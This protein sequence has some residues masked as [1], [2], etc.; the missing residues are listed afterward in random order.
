MGF[1][2]IKNNTVRKKCMTLI[3]TKKFGFRNSHPS[4][5]NYKIICA[6]PEM[7]FGSLYMDNI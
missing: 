2:K 5:W 1:N 3:F 7:A 6:N 4:L